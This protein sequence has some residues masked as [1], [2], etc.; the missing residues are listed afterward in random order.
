MRT[1]VAS[2][3]AFNIIRLQVICCHDVSQLSNYHNAILAYVH[4]TWS[5]LLN[6]PLWPRCFHIVTP[7]QPVGEHCTA[8]CEFD[9]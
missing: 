2:G 1:N 7:V 4:K 8:V 9:M 6:K 3:C 5:P